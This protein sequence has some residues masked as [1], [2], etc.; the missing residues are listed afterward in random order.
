MG[1]SLPG[2]HQEPRCKESHRLI[3][4]RSELNRTQLMARYEGL[5]ATY[6]DFN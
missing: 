6:M 1:N 5:E 3:T 4:R 2:Q